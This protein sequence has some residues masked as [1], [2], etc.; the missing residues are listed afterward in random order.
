METVGQYLKRERELRNISLNE[1][2]TATRIRE[3]LLAAIEEDRHDLLPAPVFV[4]GFLVAYGKHIGLDPDDVVL[5]YESDLKEL[6]EYEDKGPPANAK[7]GWNRGLL[8]GAIIV[9]VGIAI[10]LFNPWR[11]SKEREGQ[12]PVHV[13][14]TPIVQE[15]FTPP[16]VTPEQEDMV[17]PI[18]ETIVI[19]DAPPVET[20]PE[21]LPETPITEMMSEPK[22]VDLGGLILQIQAI[23]ET[24]I[25]LQVD[26]DLPWDITLRAGETF[27]QRANNHMKL[28]IGNAA[29]V[30]LTLNGEDL[31][32][33]GD[34]GK[35]VRLSLTPKGYEFMKRDDFEIPGYGDEVKPPDA[36]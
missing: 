21:P 3:N 12:E 22:E 14:E 33:L 7:K 34:P 27:S 9:M 11:E 28:K 1:I 20:S 17:P 31:G 6:L 4:K 25:A 2:S 29:G 10:I 24:W 8:L 15:D 18:E 30:N 16:P 32:P 13:E 5:R 26:S 19:R 23:E 36:Y 35:V